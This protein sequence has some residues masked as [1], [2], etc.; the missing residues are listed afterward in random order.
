MKPLFTVHA[1]EYLVGNFIEQKLRAPDQSKLNVWVPSKD[2]GIDILVTNVDNSLI[3]SIQ[4]KFSKDFLQS[5]LKPHFQERILAAGW[6][7]LNR[8]KIL[9]SRADFWVFV[10]HSIHSKEYNYLIITPDR[11]IKI[12]NKLHPKGQTIQTYLWI[13]KSGQCWETRGLKQNELLTIADGTYSGK[14]L[15]ERN[16]TYFL[17]NWSPFLEKFVNKGIEL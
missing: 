10:I 8:K 3:S 12:L 1:G 13:S 14:D 15:N 7:S 17:N 9:M 6:W 11:L 4:V 16:M 2:T 5:H